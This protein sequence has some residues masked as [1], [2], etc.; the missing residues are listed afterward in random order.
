MSHF[1]VFI[2]GQ[3]GTTGLQI[4]DRLLK[5][6]EITL[7]S[8]SDEERKDQNARKTM[9]NQAD[10]V[11][12]CLPD[13]AAI[14]AVGLCD[15]E[16]TIIIDASTAHRISE[17]WAYGFPEL[18]PSQRVGIASS[19]RIANPGCYATA[20]VAL[21][22]PLV[23]SGVVAPYFPI[24]CHGVSGYTGGGK[25]MIADFAKIDAPAYQPYALSLHHKHLPEMTVYS[26]LETPPIF[27]PAVANFPQGM[28]V[29]VPL[30]LWA[31]E[32]EPDLV[33][34]HAILTRHYEGEAFVRVASLEECD[35]LKNLRADALKDTNMLEI[36]VFGDVQA[37]QVRLV[38]RLDNLGKG[39]SGA[40]VQ[41]L[42]L[43][44]GLCETTGLV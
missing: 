36:F 42:N 4:R 39:A 44:L 24:S 19:K 12:L 13:E 8:L 18:N 28:I 9:I 33:D 23:E 20:F 16:K 7:L 35:G 29:E 40:A 3:A 43:A 30:P 27:T 17:G 34:L 31:L 14:E 1:K 25:S 22:H 41:N 5:R 2:D 11:I 37:L 15:N 26:G 32:S 10:A 21:M 38:A 6:D